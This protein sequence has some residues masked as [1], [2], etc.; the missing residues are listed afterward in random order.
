MAKFRENRSR[1]FR[2]PSWQ[3]WITIRRVADQRKIIRNR[4]RRDTELFDYAGL[5]AYHSGPA[6]QL[7]Y[8]RSAHTLRQILVR[9]ADYHAIDPRVARPRHRS[10]GQ[11]IV[12]FEFHHRPDDNACRGK[13]LL[14][15]RELREQV[16]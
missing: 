7:D 4:R 10:S 1:R 15:Q 16:G 2:A 13:R 11:R 6:I 9:R 14:E 8:A 5:V 3:A 12:R